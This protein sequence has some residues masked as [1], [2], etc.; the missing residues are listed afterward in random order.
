MGSHGLCRYL[1]RHHPVLE[2]GQH[3]IFQ[4]FARDLAAVGTGFVG[5]IARAGEAASATKRVRATAAAAEDQ[6]SNDFGRRALFSL[7]FLWCSR[8]ASVTLALSKAAGHAALFY[9]LDESG[10]MEPYWLQKRC[11]MANVK[12]KIK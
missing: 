11:D 3:A 1:W 9:E 2:F 6:A 7:F 12:D 4:V 8:T 5:D 10:G